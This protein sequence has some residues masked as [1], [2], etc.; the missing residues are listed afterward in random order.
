MERVKNI[1][2]LYVGIVVTIVLIEPIL[3]LLNINIDEVFALNDAEYKEY[4]YDENLYENTLKNSYEEILKNDV[5]ERLKSEGYNISNVEIKYNDETLEPEEIHLKLEYEDG[6][7]QPIKIEVS[8]SESS[9][10]NTF[11]KNKIKNIINEIYGVKKENIYILW[12]LM[13]G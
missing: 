7:V 6:Y 13:I 11:T 1:S 8:N 12:M 3:N 10:V 9:V 4:E 5:I 2:H